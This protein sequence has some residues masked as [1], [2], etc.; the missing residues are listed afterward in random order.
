M[1]SIHLKR[2]SFRP[3]RCNDRFR[4]E[5]HGKNHYYTPDFIED[6]YFVEVKGWETELDKLKYTLV[7]NLKVIYYNELKQ[8]IKF[9]QNLYNVEDISTLYTGD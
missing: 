2:L 3:V 9:V 4:Y 5:L 7:D 6:G 8:M 1:L